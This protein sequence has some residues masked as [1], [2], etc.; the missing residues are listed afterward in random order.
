MKILHICNYNEQKWASRYYATDRKI[1]NGMIRNGHFVYSASYRFL[2]RYLSPF[3]SK[4]GGINKLNKKLITIANEL[5]PDLVLLSH[6]EIVSPETLQRIRELLPDVKIAMW[7]VDTLA[8]DTATFSWQRKGVEE[9]LPFLDGFFVT[10]GGS[11][12]D[13]LKELNRNCKVEFIPNIV[14]PSIETGRAFAQNC[15]Y[16]LC[17]MASSTPDRE[18]LVAEINNT[19]KNINFC[20]RGIGNTPAASGSEFIELL[21]RS[22][23]GLN[24]SQYTNTYLYSSDRM[25]QICGNGLACLTPRTPGMDKLYNEDE[26]A[27]FSDKDSMMNQLEKL[28]MDE[29]YRTTLAQR[30]WQ[31]THNDY[32]NQRVCQY[33]LDSIHHAADDFL[34][35][36]SITSN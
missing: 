26:V 22:A 28:I 20:V 19:F 6:T 9:K 36:P 10:S 21:S 5:K 7:Y 25:A 1:S 32:N 29:N 33:I 14:D 4:R 18:A 27:Y 13:P 15:Q 30:G 24:Y 11:V 17:Y 12:L 8:A 23:I 3:R 16:D 35:Y 2:A 31:R 34:S